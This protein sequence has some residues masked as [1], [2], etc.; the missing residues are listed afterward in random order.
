MNRNFVCAGIIVFVLSQSAAAVPVLPWPYMNPGGSAP[1]SPTDAELAAAKAQQEAAQMAA[2]QQQQAQQEA[3]QQNNGTGNNELANSMGNMMPGGAGGGMQPMSAG[4]GV[5]DGGSAGTGPNGMANRYVNGCTNEIGKFGFKFG[6]VQGGV[7]PEGCDA[8]LQMS[9]DL[10]DFMAKHLNRCVIAGIGRTEEITT[11][12]I[13]HAGTMGD[14]AHQRTGSLHNFGLALDLNAIYVKTSSGTDRMYNYDNKR[15]TEAQGFFRRFRQ[16]WSDAVKSEKGHC[17]RATSTIGTIGEEDSR[18]QHHMHLSVP[19][20]ANQKP[21]GAYMT[22]MWLFS[23]ANAAEAPKKEDKL[24]GPMPPPS[25]FTKKTVKV[26]GGELKMTV[27]DT[28]GEPVSADHIITLEVVCEKKKAQVPAPIVID[29]CD[30]TDMSY[31][32]KKN[33]VTVKYRTSDLV[34]GK[35]SCRIANTKTYKLPCE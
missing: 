35:V 7:G 17:L 10:A 16:C 2:F 24:E 28:H 27:E 14:A 5:S 23:V 3:M 1:H 12:K 21:P 19:F 8:K 29:S 32:K 22:M 4:N 34:S 31:D 11:G 26:K 33:E 30:F 6:K 15:D 13:F 25:T 18:H 9:D 20:C